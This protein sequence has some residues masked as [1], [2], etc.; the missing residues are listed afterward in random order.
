V[1]SVGDSGSSRC[2]STSKTDKYMAQFKELV[3]EDRII[4]IQELAI[5]SGISFG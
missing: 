4:T 5:K 2:P 3:H 1:I